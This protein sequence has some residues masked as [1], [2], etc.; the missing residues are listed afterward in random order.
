MPSL[1]YAHEQEDRAWALGVGY[2]NDLGESDTLQDGINDNR[3]SVFEEA[4]EGGADPDDFSVA[5]TDRTGGWTLNASATFGQFQ[6]IG[7]YLSATEN[8]AADSLSFKEKG[9]RPAAWNLEAGFTFPVLGR[10]SVASVAY[11]GTREALALEL[12]KERW[13]AGWS[14]EIFDKTSLSFEWAHDIDYSASDGGTG[15]SADSV[16][17][18]LAVEF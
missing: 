12:P 18:Q 16:V 10:E 2:L 6:L 3:V 17:A 8:F 4:L 1:G 14:I 15:K 9:A 11:Q 7:E 5:P 13:L